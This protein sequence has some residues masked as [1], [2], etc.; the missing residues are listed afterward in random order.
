MSGTY[1]WL[2]YIPGF[3]NI[4][5]CLSVLPAA[6]VIF[7]YTPGLFLSTSSRSFNLNY[8]TIMAQY[9]VCV[10]SC[11]GSKHKLGIGMH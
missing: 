7:Y 10:I 2:S 1:Q 4:P 8:V 6:G 11:S 5:I 3:I 9:T